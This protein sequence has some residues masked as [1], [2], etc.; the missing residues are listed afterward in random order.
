MNLSGSRKFHET[1]AVDGI[2]RVS[3]EISGVHG[4]S[5]KV[6]KF[7]KVSR[8]IAQARVHVNSIGPKDSKR[9]RKLWGAIGK[10]EKRLRDQ[11]KNCHSVWL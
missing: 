8:L 9:T 10:I 7:V 2:R 11:E 6:E 5:C 1:M 4:L 3:N